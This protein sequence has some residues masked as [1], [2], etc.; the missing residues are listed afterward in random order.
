MRNGVRIQDPTLG[1]FVLR[2]RSMV[3]VRMSR[4]GTKKVPFYRVVVADHRRPRD[5]KFLETIGTWDPR[6]RG[7]I[8]TLDRVRYDAWLK[9]GATPSELVAKLAFKQAKAAAAAAPKA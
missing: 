2:N 9:Q 7:G 8:L 5:G 4:A 3:T 1:A 6:T